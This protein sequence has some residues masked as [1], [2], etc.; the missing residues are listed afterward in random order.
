M[1]DSPDDRPADASRADARPAGIFIAG[2]HALD[3]GGSFTGPVDVSVVE[4]RVA[5]I[6]DAGIRDAVASGLVP[7]PELQVSV[8]ALGISKVQPPNRRRSAEITPIRHPR[9]SYTCSHL[10][11]TIYDEQL[12]PPLHWPGHLPASRT[13]PGQI[14]GL[15]TEKIKIRRPN[16]RW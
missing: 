10:N 6:A 11:T 2:V 7:G 14:A 13:R 12:E 8:V 4:G 5:G 1:P 9:V 15:T 16:V 3:H